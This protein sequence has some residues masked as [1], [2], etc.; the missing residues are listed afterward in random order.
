[1]ISARLTS[2]NIYDKYFASQASPN[3]SDFGKT[4]RALAT[5]SLNNILNGRTVLHG[6]MRVGNRFFNSNLQDRYSLPGSDQDTSRDLPG[7]T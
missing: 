7:L 5:N 4:M 6:Q 3:M 2:A 1:L